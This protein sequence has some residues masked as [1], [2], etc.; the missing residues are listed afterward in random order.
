MAAFAKWLDA[1]FLTV[2]RLQGFGLVSLCH[3]GHL[4]HEYGHP[5]YQRLMWR[6]CGRKGRQFCC[7]SCAAAHRGNGR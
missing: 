2:S 6:R 7:A 4:V 1:W 5:D 3:F